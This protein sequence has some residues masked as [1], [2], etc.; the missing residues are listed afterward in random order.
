MKN[1]HNHHLHPKGSE[2][3][4]VIMAVQE[5]EC[6]V[7]GAQVLLPMTDSVRGLGQEMTPALSLNKAI[8]LF[9]TFHTA[10]P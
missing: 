4:S 2:F 10:I 3:Q 1:V 5:L 7:H 9:H 8:T 6:L